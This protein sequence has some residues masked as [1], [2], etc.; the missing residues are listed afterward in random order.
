[1]TF[2]HT[3][4]VE[5]MPF[6]PLSNRVSDTAVVRWQCHLCPLQLHIATT[7]STFASACL[8]QELDHHTFDR[9]GECEEVTRG[10]I[11]LMPVLSA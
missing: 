1:M 2:H 11:R 7:F 8:P 3:V 10:G 5:K 6:K 4:S 9:T